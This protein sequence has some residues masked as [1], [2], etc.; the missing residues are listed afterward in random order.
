MGSLLEMKAIKLGLKTTG[1]SISSLRKVRAS[2]GTQPKISKF[3]T[4]ISEF[5][6]VCNVVSDTEPSLNEKRH[7]IRDFHN[8]P[9]GS[10]LLRSDNLKGERAEQQQTEK[11]ELIV[12]DIPIFTR[13][14]KKCLLLCSILVYK[15]T[16]KGLC[17]VNLVC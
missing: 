1:S 15:N 10:K 12:D 17:L 8:V 2:V 11:E 16:Q 9:A 4:L 6:V 5:G 13:V 14:H 3:P 7:L